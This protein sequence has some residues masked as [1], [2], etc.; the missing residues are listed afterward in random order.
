[1]PPLK[2]PAINRLEKRFQTSNA[3]NV[4]CQQPTTDGTTIQAG[5]IFGAQNLNV[6]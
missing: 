4:A 5:T 3:N 2:P 6:T 1:M